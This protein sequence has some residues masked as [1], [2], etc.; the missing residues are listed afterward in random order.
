[1]HNCRVSKV[2]IP[3]IM[4]NNFATLF[5]QN[6]NIQQLFLESRFKY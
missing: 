1:M 2:C 3:L 6:V 4:I 5:R